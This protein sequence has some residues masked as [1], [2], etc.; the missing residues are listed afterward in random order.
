MERITSLF[1]CILKEKRT[2]SELGTRVMINC[3]K[4]KGEAIERG[5]YR[6]LKLLEYTIKIFERIIEKETRKLIDISEMQF[7]L[8]SGRGNI[9]AIF[10]ARQLH[11]KCLGKK[12]TL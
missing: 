7:G 1:N 12:K 6:D 3:F 11:K 5:Y 4:Q 9:D 8:M 2:P 10:I